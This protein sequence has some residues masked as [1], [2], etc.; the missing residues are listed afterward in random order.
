MINFK[1]YIDENKAFIIAEVG[2]NHQ[3][4]LEKATEYIEIFSKSGCDAIKFQARNNKYLFSEESY[5][6]NYNSE[7]AFGKTYG[8]HREYLELSPEELKL[9]KK[10]CHDNGVL[11]MCT[12]FDEP[13]LDLLISLEVDILKL[14]S[15]D[16]G[17][18]PFINL[19]SKTGKPIVMSVGGG[20]SD[21][22]KSSINEIEKYHDNLAVLHCVSEYPCEYSR[23][24]LENIKTLIDLYPNIS[25]GLSDHFN[26]ISSGPV[27]YMMGARVFEKHVTLNRSW[28]GTDHS[29]ALEP[30]GFTKFVRDIKRVPKMMPSKN[31]NSLGNE[32]V[33]K[34]LGKSIVVNKDLKKGDFLRI[35][36]L[37]GR[38]FEKEYIPVRQSAKVIGKK[39]K[40]QLK[41]MEPLMF[42]YFD[43]E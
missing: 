15:F 39:L 38:I 13:S 29:F 24:G 2:Q 23:L 22:I 34:K 31:D 9:V 3:G 7:N 27:G 35:E 33:F 5:Y 41:S 43:D 10:A 16:L 11:F 4:S 19:V 1:K 18:M 30:N 8:E 32:A 17:N 36:D 14:A 12:P 20:K 28:K 6:K 26:G 42:D 40:Q 21:E 25:I 37:S